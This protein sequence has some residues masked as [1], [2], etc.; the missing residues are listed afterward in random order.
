M[1]SDIDPKRSAQE[2]YA[3]TLVRERTRAGLTQPGIG[4]HPAV[5]VSGKLISAV[6][7]CHRPPTLRLSK[8]LDL[9][10]GL[11]KEEVF[12]AHYQAYVRE[13]GEPPAFFEYA[14]LELEASALRFYSTYVIEGLFQTEETARVLLSPGRSPEVAEELV[15]VRMERQQVLHR[16]NPPLVLAR[17]DELAV[18]RKVGPAEV[19]RRQIEHLLELMQLSHVDIVIVPDG[20]PI[21]C[22]GRDFALLSFADERADLGYVESADESSHFVEDAQEVALA[23]MFERIGNNSLSVAET[24]RLLRDLLEDL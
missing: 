24:E 4:G 13:K 22:P 18:R 1:M 14:E 5:M 19:R 11:E 2:L 3:K 10:F 8:G 12:L 21:F 9:A 17:F 15:A 6:E 20:A 23:V 7:C 16:E